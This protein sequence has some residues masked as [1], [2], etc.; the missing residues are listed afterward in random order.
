MCDCAVPVRQHRSPRAQIR[1]ARSKPRPTCWRKSKNLARKS[2]PLNFA[3]KIP[4]ALYA[5]YFALTATIDER[6]VGQ[7][8][9]EGGENCSD[10]TDL[11]SAVG[12][13]I[14]SG[15][16][17]G[18]SNDFPF[19]AGANPPCYRGTRFNLS[20]NGDR[21]YKWTAP[22]TSTFTYSR[23]RREAITTRKFYLAVHLPDCAVLP[24][25][26]PLRQ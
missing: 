2:K 9:D 8:L 6:A 23:L 14:A 10:A 19:V 1:I 4:A 18:A 17:V 5:E 7:S 16:T 12:Q 20:G 26:L 25:R 21:T 3:G 13:N 15:S 24:C 22:R 11:G